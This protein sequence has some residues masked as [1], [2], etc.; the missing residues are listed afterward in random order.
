MLAWLQRKFAFSDTGLIN[1]LIGS[2]ACAFQNFALMLQ[3]G[4]AYSFIMY[5]FVAYVSGSKFTDSKSL[6]YLGACLVCAMLLLLS[7]WF[8]Y[9]ASFA[10]SCRESGVRRVL[11]ADK[12]RKISPAF[13]K[14]NSQDIISALTNDCATLETIQT[15][16]LTQFIGSVIFIAFISLALLYSDW[17]MALA[18]LW[19]IPSSFGIIIFLAKSNL[20]S[21]LVKS[22]LTDLTHLILRLGLVTC[23]LTGAFLFSQGK[24]AMNVF[25]LFVITASRIYD[26]L[27]IALNNLSGV[28]AA[29]PALKR[30]N[31]IITQE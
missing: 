31:G 3:A 10:G 1:L 8:Q 4:L 18:V 21:E 27:E 26:P 19:V 22:I 2:M 14:A 16:F 24:L 13:V 28:I 30:I 25:I 15:H 23:S 7:S 5:M 12:V 20:R 6:Y 11:L 9:N 17:R 29:R